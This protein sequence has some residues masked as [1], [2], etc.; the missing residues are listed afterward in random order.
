M[1]TRGGE[2]R[3]SVEE[4]R[5]ASKGWSGAREIQAGQ[6]VLQTAARGS[7]WAKTAA[8]AVEQSSGRAGGGRRSAETWL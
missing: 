5:G 8:A 6:A 2:L 4:G 1:E 7:R 3:R